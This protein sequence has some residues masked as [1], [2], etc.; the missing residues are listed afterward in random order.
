MTRKLSNRIWS[1]LSLLLVLLM[2]PSCSDDDKP[3]P[4]PPPPP[5]APETPPTLLSIN[6]KLDSQLELS[7]SEDNVYTLKG[8]EGNIN[9]LNSNQKMTFACYARIDHEKAVNA[10]KAEMDEGNQYKAITLW[11]EV[12]GDNFPKYE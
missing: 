7:M 9:T 2:L 12:F 11:R 1:M 5:P 8:I 6:L 10:R 4:T 3:V